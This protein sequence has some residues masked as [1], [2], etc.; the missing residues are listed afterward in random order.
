MR[1]VYVCLCVTLH[2]T[3][4]EFLGPACKYHSRFQLC[5]AASCW[6]LLAVFL[7]KYRAMLMR[8]KDDRYDIIKFA[9]TFGA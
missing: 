6:P 2:F 7:P 3:D 4:S 8:Q 9:F 1:C 5:F